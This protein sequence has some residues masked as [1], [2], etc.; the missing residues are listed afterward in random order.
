[1]QLTNTLLSLIATQPE[2][3]Q[4]E[5]LSEINHFIIDFKEANAGSPTEKSH[6]ESAWKSVH[7]TYIGLVH[8]HFGVLGKIDKTPIVANHKRGIE[9][10]A[11]YLDITLD[12]L[13]ASGIAEQFRQR[14]NARKR[15]FTEDN[16]TLRFIP[17][18]RWA[19][20]LANLNDDED[21]IEPDPARVFSLEADA[22]ELLNVF[23]YPKAEANVRHDRTI[24]YKQGYN[25]SPDLGFSVTRTTPIRV[26]ELPDGRLALFSAKEKKSKTKHDFGAEFLGFA[27]AKAIGGNSDKADHLRRKKD[28]RMADVV[29]L[30]KQQTAYSDILK[31]I[32][33][34]LTS[35]GSESDKNGL[36]VLVGMKL[37]PELANAWIEE[38]CLNRDTGEITKID[39]KHFQFSARKRLQNI[40]IHPTSQ[41][42]VR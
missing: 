17:N 6:L 31:Q 30:S 34:Y 5:Q 42:S 13:R 8:E 21:I 39:F 37:T 14:M 16:K 38:A 9:Q 15:K 41:R 7:S 28:Q 18:D 27:T 32:R 26:S 10:S 25:V 36:I 12:E 2:N 20:Y 1:M 29:E 40:L 22:L 4:K 23:G 33:P 11:L 19:R 35:F 3:H 24:Q